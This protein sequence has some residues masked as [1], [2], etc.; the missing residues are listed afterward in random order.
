VIREVRVLLRQASPGGF[1][2][3]GTGGAVAQRRLALLAVHLMQEGFDEEAARLGQ[4]EETSGL[5]QHL[6]PEQ[7]RRLA[8]LA[9]LAVVARAHLRLG[10]HVRQPDAVP[11]AVVAHHA[12]A[13][14]AVVFTQ[15][16]RE[17]LREQ[18]RSREAD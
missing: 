11:A 1:A 17:R 5:D 8:V 2:S 6:Q 3:G 16:S 4:P 10:V 15:E 13:L 7:L 9:P 14:A 18:Q 12:A